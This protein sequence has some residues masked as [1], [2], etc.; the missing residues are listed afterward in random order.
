M[1][2]E[3][4]EAHERIAGV[5]DVDREVANADWLRAGAWDVWTADAPPRL[6]A[7]LDELRRSIGV[8]GPAPA[9]E[10]RRFL[11]LPAARAMPTSLRAE[12]SRY[13]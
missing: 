7:T 1:A 13:R 11:A 2:L 6:V 12:T 10:I 4:A 5:I 8:E 9:A 3:P